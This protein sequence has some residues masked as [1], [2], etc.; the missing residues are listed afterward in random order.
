MELAWGKKKFRQKFETN[1]PFLLKGLKHPLRLLNMLG[2][3]LYSNRFQPVHNPFL[4]W[5]LDIEPT[6]SCNL[7][8]VMCHSNKIRD[9]RE[10]KNMT[11]ESFVK[12][13]DS[14]PTLLRVTI[15]GMG[16]PLLSPDF[17]RMV[18]Y[19]SQND[20]AVTTTLNATFINKEI[21]RKIIESG[22]SRIYISLDGATKETYENIRVGA[23]FEKTLEGIR[24]LV[25][26]RKKKGRPFIDLWMVGIGDN[27]HELPL[28]VDLAAELNV[29]SL[30]LQPDVTYWGK[31]EFREKIRRKSLSNQGKA[32]AEL[33]EEAQK[34]AEEK[35]LNF[36]YVR[37]TR[38]TPG[39]P[40]VWPWQ[41]GFISTDGRMVP[42]CLLADPDIINFGNVLDIPFKEIWNGDRIKEL[43]RTIKEGKLNHYC[44]DCY[45]P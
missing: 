41:A 19:A 32:V 35:G 31:D 10:I 42:C 20:I 1:Y 14:V 6:V 43:R 18:S 45:T 37:K 26:A 44:R 12:I 17:I 9:K 5:T 28:M 2:V 16:E 15:Q 7:R 8:C 24:N 13:I 3:R 40:C 36:V 25:A 4:P 11:F 23:V 29:D 21:A 33:V 27:I 22:I 34:K 39:N 30:T 38:F